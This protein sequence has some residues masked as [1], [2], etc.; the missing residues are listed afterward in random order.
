MADYFLVQDGPRFEGQ[1]RPPLAEAWRTRNFAPCRQLCA[2]LIPA[3]LDYAQRYHTG[4]EPPLVCAVAAGLTFDRP[5]W[6]ALVGEVLL[7]G[8]IDVPEF[9]AN[10]AALCQ[11][12][13]PVGAETSPIRQALRGSR[14]LTFG[15][16]TYRP[17]RAGY[18]NAADVA[19]L[20][21]YLASVCPEAWAPEAL[22]G[23]EELAEED[24]A[25]ELEL[26]R[27][28]FPVLV[29]LYQRC[30]AEGHVLAIEEIY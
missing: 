26:V 23:L 3:A 1:V 20:A 10:E 6:R 13:P 25:D 12:L 15:V 8:A 22:R 7:F 5:C 17:D 2:G 29:A 18:N 14:D 24:R 21:D 19:R 4:P 27:E 28:W 11:L 30:R 16:A 9:P